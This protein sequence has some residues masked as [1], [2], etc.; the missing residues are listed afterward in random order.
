MNNFSYQLYSSRN[1][2]PLSKTLK[3]LGDIG[4]V[5]VEGYG[6]LFE[7]IYNLATL[8]ADLDANGLHMA[9]GHISLETLEN[10]VQSVLELT[11][12]LNIEAIYCPHLVE[13]DRPTTSKGWHEFGARLQTASKPYTDAGLIFG[14]HNHDFEFIATEDGQ[15]PMGLILEGG[16]NI[17]WEADIAWIVRGGGDPF[18]Y[19]DKYA[20][21]ISA[22]H[23]KD[24]APSGE[25]ED[26]DGWADV[27]QGTVDWQGLMD[28]L[29]STSAKYFIMEHDNPNDATRFAKRSLETAIK[30]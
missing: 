5:Q 24:I 25:N 9:S 30:Y 3:M 28:T 13:E 2:Q 23:I 4:Y 14:W 29:K 26:E 16:P 6:A 11:K 18:K 7:D 10:N 8:K 12:T 20:D 27:G 21:R 19:I 1:F 15:I 22:V 17:T